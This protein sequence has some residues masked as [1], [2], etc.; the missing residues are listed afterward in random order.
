[1]TDL[2][3]APIRIATKFS[4]WAWAFYWPGGGLMLLFG[5]LDVA[6][7]LVTLASFL[8]F[9][10]LMLFGQLDTEDSKNRLQ[11]LL[12][13]P[14]YLVLVFF[15]VLAFVPVI[16]A[17]A[18]IGIAVYGLILLAGCTYLLVMLVR[19]DRAHEGTAFAHKT[20]QMYIAAGVT[21]FSSLIIVLDGILFAS[22]VPLVQGN[23]AIGAVNWGGILYPIMVLAAGRG[24]LAPLRKPRFGT[25]K[26]TESADADLAP[27]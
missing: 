25:R 12:E 13:R 14:L 2:D 16:G 10:G 22:G 7:I 6:S 26:P 11:F 3:H 18:T 23:V 5:G 21:W 19:F 9:L 4:L 8:T 24:I 1:M 15:A 27:A 17:L 20:D